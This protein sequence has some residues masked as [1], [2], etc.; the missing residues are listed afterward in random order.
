[1]KLNIDRRLC[2]TIKNYNLFQRSREKINLDFRREIRM[3]LGIVYC[4]SLLYLPMFGRE[5]NRVAYDVYSSVSE[6]GKSRS[7]ICSLFC[8]MFSCLRCS[9]CRCESRIIFRI[10]QKAVSSIIGAASLRLPCLHVIVDILNFRDEFYDYYY[11]NYVLSLWPFFYISKD[12]L[13]I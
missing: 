13:F 9:F 7:R 8:L 2:G 5:P 6:L 10:S 4:T 11:Y 12:N 1:V 3:L